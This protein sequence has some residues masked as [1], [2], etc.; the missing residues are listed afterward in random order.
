M[1]DYGFNKENN[2]ENTNLNNSDSNVN[3]E[4]NNN[5]NSIGADNNTAGSGEANNDI[6]AGNDFIMVNYSMSDSRS[7]AQASVDQNAKVDSEPGMQANRTS[8]IQ[9]NES[10]YT[11]AAAPVYYKENYKKTKGNKSNGNKTN[12]LQLILVALMSSIIGGGIV[13][14]AIQFIS[15]VIQPGVTGILN[16]AGIKT[17][18]T[19][20][21]G[22]S[23]DNGIYKK[24]EITKSDSA[25]TAIA[26]KVS[27]SIVGIK[28]T[29][30]S[31]DFFLQQSESTGE[32]SGIIIKEDGYILTNYHV[33]EGAL[34]SNTN[35]LAQ[36][37][38]IEVILPENKDKSY[39]A[40]VVGKDSK[41]DLAVLKINAGKK[42]TA[43][44]IG[45]SS[46]LKQGELAVAI[47]NPG[48]LEYMGSV[49]AG[50]ISGLNRT[51]TTEDGKTLTLIQTDAAIN[52]G[53]SGGALCNSQ[54]QV[55]GINTIKITA[56][57]FEGLGFAIPINSA[58]ETA[59]NLIEYKYIKG[60]PLIGVSIRQEI[61]AATAKQYDV[62]EGILVDSVT[63]LGAADNAGI[64]RNDII[65]KFDGQAINT[66]A[67]LE[68]LK[69]KHK[70]G[71]KVSVE[72]Y[73]Y[74][75]KTTKTLT[76]IL[77]EDK[78]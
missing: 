48:G 11:P 30:Q 58:K 60:R 32:G 54:G 3:N 29:A 45:D 20:A 22:T 69:N 38:K 46:T 25:V 14:A 34:S 65:T 8:T 40:T 37:A 75:E 51:I 59:D 26:E 23:T 72:I 12:V 67:K 44:E 17:E 43:A 53:N 10:F 77:G 64:Q 31:Q 35:T 36:G 57:G 71:D 49:T 7:N 55:I 61:D 19:A 16:S 76:L 62:P 39:V 50:I 4:V 15:P 1:E 66:Y 27:P 73:R 6:N 68:E 47:G 28:V 63:T 41:S 33:I 18:V 74:N 2:Q 42:L 13:F 24:V 70:P 56:T 52:P 78:S 5:F 21:T 9:T